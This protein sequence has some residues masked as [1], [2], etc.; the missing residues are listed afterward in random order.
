MIC[1]MVAF[2][3]RLRYA[4]GYDAPDSAANFFFWFMHSVTLTLHGKAARR[5]AIGTSHS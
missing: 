4:F 5:L 1:E 2:L 3:H